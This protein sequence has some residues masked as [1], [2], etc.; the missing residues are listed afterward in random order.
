MSTTGI[1]IQMNAVDQTTSV[2]AAVRG[3]FVALQQ[4]IS[5]RSAMI[6][7]SG[8]RA[9]S[10]WEK[11]GARIIGIRYAFSSLYAISS[12]LSAPFRRVAA[13]MHELTDRATEVGAKASDIQRLTAAFDELGV[14]HAGLEDVVRMLNFMQKSTGDRGVE[15]LRRH[16]AAI[17]EIGDSTQRA[18]E[19]T[20]VFGREGIRLEFLLRKG[21]DAFLSAL[22]RVM[23]AMPAMSESAIQAASQ[24]DKG[25]AW[26]SRDIKNGWNDLIAGMIQSWTGD[27]GG[28]VELELALLWEDF[29]GW[30]ER[31]RNYAAATC[32]FL[33]DVARNMFV[34]LPKGLWESLKLMGSMVAEFGRQFWDMITG[35]TFDTSALAEKLRE[36]LEKIGSK[37]SFGDWFANAAD[38]NA[39]VAR[40]VERTKR[41]ILEAFSAADALGEGAGGTLFDEIADAGVS[42]AAKISNAWKGTGAILAGS[43]EAVKLQALRAFGAA[44]GA[45]KFARDAIRGGASPAATSRPS[46]SKEAKSLA[47]ILSRLAELLD[48][49][50]NGWGSIESV[51]GALETV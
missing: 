49:Q 44:G 33:W 15:G 26:I 9:L 41:K 16:L 34:G 42:A 13:E 47:S 28:N 39:A 51:L 1:T 14:K 43:Y 30:F 31:I 12:R 10:G 8:E 25:F 24:V 27:L 21:P 36:G 45:A 48:V 29:K 32:L 20:R 4:S 5:E 22:D 6:E 50:R 7:G 11:F 38:E 17:A 40:N 37:V 19:L 18:A 2:L 35:G 3:R 46:E 23:A